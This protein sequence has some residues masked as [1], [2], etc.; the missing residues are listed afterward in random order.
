MTDAAI[1]DGTDSSAL[2]WKLRDHGFAILPGVIESSYCD[3]VIS[4]CVEIQD[5]GA[6][7]RTLL[8]QSWCAGLAQLLQRHEILQTL[9][10]EDAVAVQCTLFDKS[11]DN[12]WLVSLHQDLSIPVKRRVASAECSGWSAKEGTVFVQPP[13]SVLEQLVAVRICI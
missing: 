13:V 6:K 7:S 3:D 12:N 8:V 11:V 2:Q 9:L 4:R 1:V 5:L 10:P